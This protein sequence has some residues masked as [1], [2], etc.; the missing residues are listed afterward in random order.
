MKAMR[1]AGKEVFRRH[2]SFL[3]NPQG[4]VS[5]MLYEARELLTRGLGHNVYQQHLRYRE[6]TD[7]DEEFEHEREKQQKSLAGH[8]TTPS[9]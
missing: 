7:V 3:G 9:P 8:H 6:D 2:F 5:S 4:V 1:E